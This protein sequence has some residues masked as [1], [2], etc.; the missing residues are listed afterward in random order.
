[1]IARLAGTVADI[2][3]D[4]L[5]ID[6]NGVGYAV[7]VPLRNAEG[8][9]E[10]DAVTVWVYTAVREDAITL[11]G[12]LT[13]EE[14]AVF[15]QL[16]SVS[17]V[18][19][20]LG[21]NALSK[22]T[23]NA[24]AAAIEGNDLRALSSITGVGKK[25]AERIVLEL[26]GKMAVAPAGAPAGIAAPARVADDGFAIA[27]AQLGYKRSE[28]DLAIERLRAEGLLERPLGERI[29][30]ALRVLTSGTGYARPTERA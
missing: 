23:A 2:R 26:R 29:T 12:F 24:L 10:G 9:N 14:K 15:E 18:G 13:R 7:G 27:L 25:T 28:I 19:P 6:V 11:Y 8:L 5:V 20:R 4:Q 17:Q 16:I 3:G 1:M 30:A 22:F 21:L